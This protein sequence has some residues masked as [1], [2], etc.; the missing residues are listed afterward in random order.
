MVIM[1]LIYAQR[2]HLWKSNTNTCL[3]T[4]V[5]PRKIPKKIKWKCKQQL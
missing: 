5:K 3:H 4:A 2:L 1:K